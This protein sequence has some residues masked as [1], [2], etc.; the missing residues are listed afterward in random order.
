V[1]NYFGSFDEI[2]HWGLPEN[3]CNL[4]ELIGRV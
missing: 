1:F 4:N 2:T 3:R